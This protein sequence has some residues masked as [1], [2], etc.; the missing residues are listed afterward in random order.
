MASFQIFTRPAEEAAYMAAAIRCVTEARKI[1]PSSVNY[2]HTSSPIQV[3]SGY[4][5]QDQTT[6]LADLRE[7]L[8]T[9]RDGYLNSWFGV[10][11]DRMVW[12]INSMAKKI[13][14]ARV[15]NC[16]ELSVLVAYLL[17][18]SVVRAWAW[19]PI[20]IVTVDS[21]DGEDTIVNSSVLPHWFVVI[22]RRGKPFAHNADI[23][24]PREWGT[25]A[26]VAD[27]WDRVAYPARYHENYWNGLLAANGDH[28]LKCVVK[29]RV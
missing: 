28:A 26:V 23:G 8:R 20:E 15:G 7:Q 6:A 10:E 19:T 13:Q 27:G 29:Y 3:P 2:Q 22:G 24:L 14:Q 12:M 5:F 21:A 25:A 1:V 11:R 16:H 17:R 18:Q 9:I 4:L